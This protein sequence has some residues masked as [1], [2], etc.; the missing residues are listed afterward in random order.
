MMQAP[1]KS[2]IMLVIGF[3]DYMILAGPIPN[4]ANNVSFTRWPIICRGC[5]WLA[6]M[7]DASGSIFS[8]HH[9]CDGWR[10]RFKLISQ[11]RGLIARSLIDAPHGS[12]L[13]VRWNMIESRDIPYENVRLFLCNW[14]GHGNSDHGL[15]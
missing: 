6:V 8:W 5:L 15:V 10:E 2:S 12:N 14:K 7:V 11:L 3:D 1:L 9:A 4:N 13:L